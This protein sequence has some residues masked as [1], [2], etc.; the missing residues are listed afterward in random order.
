[1]RMARLGALAAF[2]LTQPAAQAQ[3]AFEPDAPEVPDAPSAE[4]SPETAMRARVAAEFPDGSLVGFRNVRRIRTEAG[5]EIEFCGQVN[6]VEGDEP[7]PHYR[8]FLYD[9]DG[10]IERVRILGADALNGYRVGRKLIG[11]LKRVGCL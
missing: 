9:R 1:M 10:A 11:A 6:V 4:A 2:L 5:H 8:I 7:Q 3:D